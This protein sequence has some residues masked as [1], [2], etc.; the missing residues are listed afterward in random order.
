MLLSVMC[1]SL[2]TRFFCPVYLFSIGP[3]S[4][5]KFSSASWQFFPFETSWRGSEHAF[6][7]NYFQVH[8]STL[9]VI[10]IQLIVC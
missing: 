10:G 9:L 6:L 5:L 8:N 1:V 4:A 7:L 2:L 3:D